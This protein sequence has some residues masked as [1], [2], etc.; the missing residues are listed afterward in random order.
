MISIKEAVHANVEASREIYAWA[1]ALCIGLGASDA[2]LVPFEKYAKA[3]AGLTNPSSAARALFTGAKHI[4]RVD[5]LIRQIA[6][7]QGLSCK[8]VG[9][10][11]E[12]VDQRL[13]RNRAAT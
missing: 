9:E 3:A 11:V 7:L 12:L 8:A 13:E 5:C 4:E 6:L 1:R 2:D 10:I